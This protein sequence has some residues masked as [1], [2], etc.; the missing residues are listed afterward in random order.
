MKSLSRYKL[1]DKDINILEDEISQIEHTNHLMP[2]SIY[3][4][5]TGKWMIVIDALWWNS[6]KYLYFMS[7]YLEMDRESMH[8]LNRC[9]DI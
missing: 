8:L 9:L 6:L 4:T 3:E 5:T 2:F 1:I 7:S